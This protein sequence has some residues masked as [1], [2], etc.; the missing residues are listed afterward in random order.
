MAADAGL[1]C[2][3]K[4][5]AIITDSIG[6]SAGMK[7]N[8]PHPYLVIEYIL[9]YGVWYQQAPYRLQVYGKGISTLQLL[10]KFKRRAGS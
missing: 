2:D 6:N 4:A 9:Q 3:A 10:S 1:P 7:L 8:P 5:L